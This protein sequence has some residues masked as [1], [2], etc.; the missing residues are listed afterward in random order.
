[1]EDDGLTEYEEQ[2]LE[3]EFYDAPTEQSFWKPTKEPKKIGLKDDWV[4]PTYW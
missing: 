1:M 4:E 3:D 2:E